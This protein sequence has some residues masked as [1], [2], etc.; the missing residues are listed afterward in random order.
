MGN[1]IDDY[2]KILMLPENYILN[3]IEKLTDGSILQW[4]NDLN[5]LSETKRRKVERIIDRMSFEEWREFKDDPE[6]KAVFDHY[7]LEIKRVERKSN[8][9]SNQPELCYV[10]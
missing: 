6:A 9:A 3:R 4:W 1:D 8:V 10:D 5:A 2:M 7:E